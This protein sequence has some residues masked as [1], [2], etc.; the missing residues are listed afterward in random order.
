MTT[1]VLDYND[2]LHS[3]EIVLPMLATGY[4]GENLYAKNFETVT[5]TIACYQNMSQDLFLLRV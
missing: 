3:V 1:M 5:Y 2:S 4:L